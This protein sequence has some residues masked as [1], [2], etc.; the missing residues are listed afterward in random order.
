MVGLTDFWVW[1]GGELFYCD[2]SG[3]I[4]YPFFFGGGLVRV[5]WGWAGGWGLIDGV[6][7]EF[8]CWSCELD[9]VWAG[10]VA[11]I[12]SGSFYGLW[13][14]TGRVLGFGRVDWAVF[15]GRFLFPCLDIIC[16]Y[17]AGACLVDG[18]W[19]GAH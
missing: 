5:R 11:V 16:V 13:V 12:W 4:G 9:V 2:I 7:I 8:R 10:L 6:G 17:S 18:R 1:F 19:V 3:S 15:F 14:I